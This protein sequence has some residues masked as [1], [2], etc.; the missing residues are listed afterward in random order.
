MT[1]QYRAALRRVDANAVADLVSLEGY[2]AGRLTAQVLEACGDAPTPAGFLAKVAEV[3]RFRVG[4][5]DLRYG[6]EDNQGSN[7]VF[8]TRIEANG[9]LAALTRLR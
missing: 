3:G 2:I 5:F 1:Q 8:L 4:G 9:E 6:P 7:R